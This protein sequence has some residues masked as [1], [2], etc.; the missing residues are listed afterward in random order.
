MPD[1]APMVRQGRVGL[2]FRHRRLRPAL[3]VPS[4]IERRASRS[5]A[6]GLSHG[7]RFT[8]YGSTVYV[9]I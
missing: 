4:R 6:R 9:L 1:Y 5:D 2:Q 8:L 3:R 7:P